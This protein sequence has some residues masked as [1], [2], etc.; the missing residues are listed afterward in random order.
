MQYFLII[1]LTTLSVWTI[2]N[3]LDKRG[4]REVDRIVHSQSAIYETIKHF[5]PQEMFK[6]PTI[7]TQSMKSSQKNMIKVLM[8]GAKAYWVVDNIFYVADVFNGRIDQST[9]QPLDIYDLSKNE[10]NK[11]MDILDALGKGKSPDDSSS[12]G[13]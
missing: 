13:N 6:K 5:I 3:I 10:L 12:T 7:V 1:V 11:L 4:I 8:D 2:I 9:I